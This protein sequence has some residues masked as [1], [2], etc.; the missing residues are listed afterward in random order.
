MI[1][2]WIGGIHGPKED[3]NVIEFTGSKEIL[4]FAKEE[5]F[6]T[7]RM[8]FEDKNADGRESFNVFEI[9]EEEFEKMGRYDD[10]WDIYEE[11]KK[12]M[13]WKD[14]W[15]WWRYSGGCVLEDSEPVTIININNHALNAWYSVD[16]LS[17]YDDDDDPK[18]AFDEW[19][20]DHTNYKTIFDYC[21]DMWGV[22]TE[23]NITAVAVG[24]AKLNHMSLATLFSIT[25]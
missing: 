18:K 16:P 15:G 19:M 21:S 10:P 25:T 11:G 9:S 4:D 17:C 12:H 22:S 2:K 13:I 24:L 14:S 3:I 20:D 5:G 6:E 23:K 7:I 8:T 1:L